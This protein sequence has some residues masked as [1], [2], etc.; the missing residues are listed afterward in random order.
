M[1]CTFFQNVTVFL[2]VASSRRWARETDRMTT[3][4]MNLISIKL[5]EPVSELHTEQLYL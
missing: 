3:S 5:T 2:V 1:E 4:V